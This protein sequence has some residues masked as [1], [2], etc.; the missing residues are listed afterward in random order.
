MDRITAI[1][2]ELLRIFWAKGESV[3]R[4]VYN[5]L[6]KKGHRNYFIFGDTLD[7]MVRRGLLN[8]RMTESNRYK[9]YVVIPKE[10]TI[11]NA[12]KELVSCCLDDNVTLL[13]EYYLKHDKFNRDEIDRLRQIID[14]LYERKK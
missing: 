4:D 9:Y 1:E 2:W 10:T 5:E 8:R 6:V 12:L 13:I 11:Q 14:E 7:K 3:A